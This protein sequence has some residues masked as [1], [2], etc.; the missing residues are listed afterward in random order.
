MSVS[1][2]PTL[3]AA[4]FAVVVHTILLGVVAS[5]RISLLRESRSPVIITLVQQATPL[6]V[7]ESG[8]E[9]PHVVPVPLL[10]SSPPISK[11]PQRKRIVTSKPPVTKNLSPPLKLVQIKPSPPPEQQKEVH[12]LAATS[13]PI[14]PQELGE[15]TS[16]PPDGSTQADDREKTG[17]QNSGAEVNA[18]STADATSGVIGAGKGDRKGAAGN[19]ENALARPSYGVNPKPVYPLLA[20]RSGAQGEVVLRIHVRPDG[21]VATVE[22]ARSSGFALLDESATRTVRESW[23]FIPARLDGVAIESWVEVPIKFVLAES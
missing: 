11:P 17:V 21:S 7:A 6:P 13:P 8:G 4:L 5:V 20:R 16:F 1:R 14:T 9:T 19:G 22:L 15:S 2:W 3:S 12:Q 23:R 18:N 10:P